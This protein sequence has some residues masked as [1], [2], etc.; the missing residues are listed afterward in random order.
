MK[1]KII[2]IVFA[3][4]F[5]SGCGRNIPATISDLKST[6]YGYHP[7]DP[8]PVH[9]VNCD[10]TAISNLRILQALPDE[11]MRLAI[12][13]ISASGGIKF[14]A[15]SIGYEGSSYVVTLDY[16][17]FTTESQGVKMQKNLNEHMTFASLDSLDPDIIVP[18][19]V[20]IGLRLTANITVNK[21]TV[22]LGNLLSIGAEVSMGKVSGF[23][24]VQT[25][26]ISGESISPLI[27]MPNEINSTTIQNAIMALGA[28]KT[29]LYDDKTMITPRVVGVYNNLGNGV[30]T[31]NQFISSILQKPRELKVE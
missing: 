5:I 2:Y 10:T 25:L 23:L 28:I 8:L 11:T 29:K 6:S 12:G 24:V 13:Q 17:K 22:N 9:M 18:I 19:Y 20:G 1:L 31:I 3:I 4:P 27:P 7:L 26:G 30:E 15:T 14:S 21:G 16:I